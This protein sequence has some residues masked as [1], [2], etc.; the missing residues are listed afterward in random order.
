MIRHATAADSIAVAGLGKQFAAAADT[1]FAF[2]AAYAEARA[3]Q[4]ILDPNG[5]CLLWDVGRPV[6][7]L[8]ATVG[9]H[10]LFPVLWAQELLWWI[11]PEHRGAG[12]AMI[13]AFEAWARERGA[14]VAKL[15]ALD[16]RAGVLMRRAGYALAPETHWLKR[17]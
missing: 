5:V 3:R 10:P 13:A 17:L 14:D 6:G 1:G 4:V 16:P 12:R 11:D 9:L 8:A 2:D 7:V 15:S